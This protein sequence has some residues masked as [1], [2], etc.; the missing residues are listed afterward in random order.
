MELWLLYFLCLFL[1]YLAGRYVERR[2]KAQ[3]YSALPQNEDEMPLQST[4]LAETSEVSGLREQL[5]KEQE[6]T[7][8]RSP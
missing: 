6:I 4:Q 7:R 2:L 5:G 8:V 1:G 3:E